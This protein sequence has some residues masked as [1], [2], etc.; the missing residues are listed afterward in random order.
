MPRLA[1]VSSPGSVKSHV[2]PSAESLTTFLQD[3]FKATISSCS[4]SPGG[5]HKGVSVSL[6]Q[7]SEIQQWLGDLK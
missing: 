6:W 2:L 3:G 7:G 5:V 4:R 1:T